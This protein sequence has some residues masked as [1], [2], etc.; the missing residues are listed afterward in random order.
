MPLSTRVGSVYVDNPSS[1]NA[2]CY[3]IL[4]DSRSIEL[5]TKPLGIKGT[6]LHDA[7]VSTIHGDFA[8]GAIV[9]HQSFFPFDLQRMFTSS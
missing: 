5:L 4:L 1:L 3:L 8:L 7:E 6:W 9:V 2:N